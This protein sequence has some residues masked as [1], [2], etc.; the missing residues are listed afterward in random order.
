MTSMTRK[1]FKAIADAMRD[2]KPQFHNL[3]QETAF[4]RAEILKQWETDCTTLARTLRQFNPLFD[5]DKFLDA[6][7]V[8]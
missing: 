8:K 2:T 5:K 4:W 7:G 3:T 1:H 6:C